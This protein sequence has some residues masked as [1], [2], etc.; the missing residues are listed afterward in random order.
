MIL[1][2]TPPPSHSFV[3]FVTSKTRRCGLS[4]RCGIEAQRAGGADVGILGGRCRRVG[5]DDDANNSR[6]RGAVS[7]FLPG[8]GAVMVTAAVIRR[9]AAATAV[10]G[11]GMFI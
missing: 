6:G 10:L 11:V 9:S 8:E 7:L 1:P 3:L 2:P 5:H 4:A